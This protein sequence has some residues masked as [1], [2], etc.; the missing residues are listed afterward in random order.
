MNIPEQPFDTKLIETIRIASTIQGWMSDI[1][2]H[3]L[4][5]TA[6]MLGENRVFVEIGSYRG[7][8]TVAIGRSLGNGA[9]LYCVDTWQG[10]LY[11]TEDLNVDLYSIWLG[12]VLGH[13]FARPIVPIR[14][15]SARASELFATS[16]IDWVFI[17]GSHL[18]EHI[19]KD[20]ALWLPKLRP[21]GIISGHD[22]VDD[23]PG[24]IGAVDNSFPERSIEDK[25][26]WAR[27]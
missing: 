6:S 19:S 20:I 17:D 26:W 15:P 2:L 11:D 10:D 25:I 13:A 22:Y 18:F 9:L 14:Q 24:V 16:S 12:N 1:E 5:A 7:R 3:W 23:C 8:S 27:V 21:G 4:I